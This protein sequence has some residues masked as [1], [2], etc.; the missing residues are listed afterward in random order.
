M[1]NLSIQELAGL[2]ENEA[3]TKIRD[4]V[5]KAREKYTRAALHGDKEAWEC[6]ARMHE[7]EPCL[8]G[9]LR[10][11]QVPEPSAAG[12]AHVPAP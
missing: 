5:I 8:R 4:A 6:L 2:D 11:L 9:Y 10:L 3:A 7:S 1:L 12:A